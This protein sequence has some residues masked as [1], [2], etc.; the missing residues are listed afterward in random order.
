MVTFWNLVVG[1]LKPSL[2]VMLRPSLTGVTEHVAPDWSFSGFLN[3]RL[4][5]AVTA[6]FSEAIPIR[7]FL[8]RLNN[9]FAFSLF[10]EVNVPG[11]KIGAKGQLVDG[12]LGEYCARQESLAETL[13]NKMIPILLDIQSFYRS[14]GAGFLY[15]ITPSKAAHLP[16]YFVDRVDCPSTALARTEMIPD[17]AERLRI[18]GV[19]I[20]DAA[21]LVHGLK[22]SYPVELFPQGGIHWNSLGTALASLEMLRTI[23]AQ[24]GHEILSPFEFDYTMARPM[25]ADRDLADLINV[26]FPPV[27]YLTP[28][29]RYKPSSPC[30][31]HP[32]RL[33]DAAIVG[34]SF[35]HGPL[36]VLREAG[37]MSNLVLY[38]YLRRALFGGVPYLPLEPNPDLQHL[39]DI[40][41]LLLEENE[42]SV[43]RSGYVDAL[44]T[45]LVDQKV[46]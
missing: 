18:A 16:E 30:D 22:G 12:D 46:R 41:L 15:V 2:F 19:T 5:A 34:S 4:Q 20:L 10:G 39:R 11:I 44:H 14:R 25:A 9:Q 7:S 42:V 40:K 13:A 45:L 37:C 29:L 23:N 27:A 35:M 24:A 28:K 17:Y 43:G 26:M 3:G 8:V 38:F 21:T 33:I 32:A 31:S 36:E 6:K 1:A